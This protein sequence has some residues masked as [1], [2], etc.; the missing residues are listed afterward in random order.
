MIAAGSVFGLVYYGIQVKDNVKNQVATDAAV[1]NY[2][3]GK[4]IADGRPAAQD[5]DITVTN[6]VKYVDKSACG[7]L[8]TCCLYTVVFH[9]HGELTF[10][11]VTQQTVSS[12]TG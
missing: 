3:S 8:L 11:L 2:E 7:M 9:P 4:P 10:G 6:P 12:R 1:R 5:P